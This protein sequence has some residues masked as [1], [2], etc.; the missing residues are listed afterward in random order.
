MAD[1]IQPF[2]D[3][4]D[5]HKLCGRLPLGPLGTFVMKEHETKLDY[6]QYV[7]WIEEH[8]FLHESNGAPPGFAYTKRT[9]AAYCAA[10]ALIIAET[11]GPDAALMWKLANG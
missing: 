7:A 6:Q 8:T 2:R 11:E 10:K 1:P 9:M 4:F 3:E 5:S